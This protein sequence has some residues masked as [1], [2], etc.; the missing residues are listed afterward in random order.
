MPRASTPTHHLTMGLN[1][2]LDE[3]AKQA[4]RE[5]IALIQ[6]LTDLTAEDAYTLCSL[7]VDMRITQLVD[8]NKGVH[9]MLPKALL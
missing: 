1:E 8:G 2:D 7:A 9:A 4:L 3:A 6:E 5:M